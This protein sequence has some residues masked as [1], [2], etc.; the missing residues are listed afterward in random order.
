MDCYICGDRVVSMSNLHLTPA[1]QRGY[2][3]KCNEKIGNKKMTWEGD[4]IGPEEKKITFDDMSISIE[5][6]EA[7]YRRSVK[8][9]KERVEL[10]IQGVEAAEK[11]F[12]AIKA[13]K[14]KQFERFGECIKGDFALYFQSLR[15]K[16]L[17]VQKLQEIEKEK[18]KTW[19][20]VFERFKAIQE[21]RYGKLTL[22]RIADELDK[23]PPKA[24][25]IKKPPSRQVFAKKRKRR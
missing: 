4:L 1:G 16:S 23:D 12:K 13:E 7:G 8:S 22:S 2:C 24:I 15:V 17:A 19:F 10:I 11:R 20:E 3:G 9:I 14:L 25:D 18:D 21:A 5:I 6:S